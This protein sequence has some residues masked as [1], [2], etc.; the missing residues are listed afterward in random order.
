MIAALLF[1]CSGGPADPAHV[2]EKGARAATLLY[3]G[4]VDGDIE[5][6]G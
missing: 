1:A 4:N 5:P 2:E 6:C 3:S